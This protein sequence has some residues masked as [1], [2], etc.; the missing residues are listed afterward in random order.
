MGVGTHSLTQ[1][2]VS[3]AQRV[4]LLRVLTA[5]LLSL[6]RQPR[7][8]VSGRAVLGFSFLTPP[9]ST[10]LCIAWILTVCSTG[11]A[12]R[13]ELR[14][15]GARS[16]KLLLGKSSAAFNCFEDLNI[17]VFLKLRRY[18]AGFWRGMRSCWCGFS[19]SRTAHRLSSRM[20]VSWSCFLPCVLLRVL[21]F[22]LINP[23]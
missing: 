7:P 22:L 21:V 23:T 18:R 1:T 9:C 4:Q 15:S 5:N 13:E 6:T 10:L 14:R 17:L 11:S 8:T 19:C 12:R 16:H 2:D 20:L 3:C